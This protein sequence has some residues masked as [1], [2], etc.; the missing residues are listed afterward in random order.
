MAEKQIAG[1]AHGEDGV[2]F[3]SGGLQRR[4]KGGLPP[5]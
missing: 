3:T 5:D 2:T 1:L 4:A